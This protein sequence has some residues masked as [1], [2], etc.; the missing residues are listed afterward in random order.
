MKIGA[1]RLARPP[2]CF[3]TC[4]HQRQRG[5]ANIRAIG[6]AEIDQ[7]PAAAEIRIGFRLPVLI[8]QREWSADLRRALL[9]PRVA[10]AALLCL[11]PERRPRPRSRAQAIYGI[12]ACGVRSMAGL[13][14]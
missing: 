14:D 3:S 4:A 8:G 12:S 2:S 10:Q 6:V 13:I 5:G 7:H 11:V 1:K 9:S